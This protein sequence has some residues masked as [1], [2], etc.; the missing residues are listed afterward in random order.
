MTGTS[1]R[2]D[3]LIIAVWSG[4]NFT[5]LLCLLFGFM[6]WVDFLKMVGIT[7]CIHLLGEAWRAWRRA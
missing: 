5:L 7:I 6:T 2:D 1:P 3:D 4:Q